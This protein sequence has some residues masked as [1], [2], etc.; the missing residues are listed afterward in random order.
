MKVVA[1]VVAL[2]LLSGVAVAKDRIAANAAGEN[3]APASSFTV[4]NYYK[5]DVYDKADKKV[6]AIDDVLISKDG[7]IDALIVGVGGFLGV[8]EK[9]VSVPFRAV[10][11]TKK[12]DKWYLT[13]DA[14]K[15]QLKAASGLKYDRTTTSWVADKDHAAANTSK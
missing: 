12:N 1:S 7:R 6:G 14:N 13:M 15:D 9:D 3:S 8:G 11:L 2:S 5:Q 4:T 10:Q